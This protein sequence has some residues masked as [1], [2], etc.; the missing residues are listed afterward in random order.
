MASKEVLRKTY[1]EKRLTLTRAEYELRNSLLLNRILEEIDYSAIHIIHSF[2]SIKKNKEVDTFQIL[3]AI[4]KKKPEQKIAVSKTRP[5]RDL[6]HFLLTNFD[7]LEINSWGIPEPKTGK[8]VDASE[9]DFIFVPLIS[10]DRLGNR[11]GYGG[12]YYDKFMAELPD[13]C[14]KV[15]L[16]LSPP[17]DEIIFV[18][19]F[20]IR[21]DICVTPLKTYS[22]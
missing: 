12:G 1:L 4:K 11:I 6:D 5:P 14:L 21:L 7:D 19:E 9:I 3:E 17:L 8:P 15:G 10:F 20:D 2:L 16:S 18:E 13:R 22:F